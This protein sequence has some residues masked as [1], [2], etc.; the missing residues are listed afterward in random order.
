MVEVESFTL[1]HTAVKAPYVRFIG[2]EAGPSG[3]VISSFDLRFVQPNHD[4]IPTGGM[5][6][7]EHLLATLLRERMDGII[8]CSPFGCRTGFHMITWGHPSVREVTRALTGALRAIA[9]DVTWADVGGTEPRECGNYRDHSL[10]TAKEWAR[11]IVDEG[12]SLDPYERQV[13]E[14]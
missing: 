12:I 3:D 14:P 7:L 2:E 1:D 6:T 4:S 9:E 5:H 10:F 13:E 8:D 11:Q